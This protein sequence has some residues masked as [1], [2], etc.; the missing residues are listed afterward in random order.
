MDLHL[1]N[2]DELSSIQIVEIFD[3]TKRLREHKSKRL[4][5]GKNFILFFPESSLRTRVT[6][7]KGIQ[8]LG[9][10]CIVFSPETLDRREKLVDTIKY[11]ENWA[12]GIVVRH[13]DF[14][15]IKEMAK[16]STIP[17]VNAMT[18]VNHPCEIL[19]DLYSISEEKSNYRD[20][21]YT[22]VGPAGNISRS[23]TDVAKVMNLNFNH[24]SSAGNEITEQS[25]NYRFHTELE[26]VL[27]HSDVVL[28]DSLPSQFRTD[29]YIPK[30]QITLERMM[31]TK[32]NSML[33]P[34]P[35]FFRNEEVSEDVICSDYFVGHSF[36]KNLLHVHQAILL[37][38]LSN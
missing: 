20:L 36:K 15:K 28:T 19:A 25:H 6:F 14:A 27:K 37:Y 21:V 12:D 8:D 13:S 33:N 11:I 2:V 5:Q 35:P 3:L 4:L 16:H 17:I 32:K 18:S 34:C 30:Y 10:E 1:L 29:E 26:E 7:E 31:L 22:F 9:G 23:W 38:C 24:V